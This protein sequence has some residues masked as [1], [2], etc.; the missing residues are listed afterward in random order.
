MKKKFPKGLVFSIPYNVTKFVNASI[1]EVV[2]T[3]LQAAI[4]VVI[5][6]F[7]FLQSMRST[8][9]PMVAMIVSI[10]GTFTGLYFFGLSINSLT[11]FGMILSI[12]IVVDDAIVVIENVERNMRE[13]GLSPIEASKKAMLEVTG[14]IIAIVFVLLAVFLPVTLLGGIAGQLY[15]Q[16]AI[17]IV[18]SVIISGIVALTLS[19]ALATLLLRKDHN[20]SKFALWFNNNLNKVTNFYI[21][22]VNWLILKTVLSLS[23]FGLLILFIVL[24]FKIIPTSF[25]PSEDQGYVMAVAIL[26]DGASLS[27]T[28]AVTSQVETIA[29]EN[30]AVQDIVSITGYSLL[31]G[32]NKTNTASYFIILK[33][34]NERNSRA[35]HAENVLKKLYSKFFLVTDALILPFNPPSIQGLGTVGGFEFW[36]QNRGSGD[37]NTL[38]NEAENFIAAALLRPEL[39]NVNTTIDMN[40]KQLYIDLDRVKTLALDIPIAD[41]YQSLQV[42]LGS[43]YV[44]DFNKF[45][46]V[47]KVMLQAEPEY[48]EA[49]WKISMKFIFVPI[50]IL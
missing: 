25:V 31:E 37:L 35:L 10:V 36:L 6:V 2:K 1:H 4:L 32:V 8:I 42:L 28:S 14:P 50:L 16:F 29:K 21:R 11:L 18:I 27:R 19:P 41:V 46:K 3:I 45:G 40:A 49:T 47:Y 23:L 20:P 22:G 33:D 13:L 24:L 48:S 15:K 17:T 43:L 30:T 26:P 44:N 12:G 9:I 34:W 5:I 38:Q 39:S 7:V